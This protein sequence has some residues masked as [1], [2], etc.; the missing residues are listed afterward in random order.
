MEQAAKTPRPRQITIAIWL[1]IAEGVLFLIAA[2]FRQDWSDPWSFVTT[3]LFA[4]FTL[5][6]IYLILR[7]KGWVRWVLA[8]LTLFVCVSTG[9]MTKPGYNWE[10]ANKLFLAAFVLKRVLAFTEL[11]LLFSSPA[12]AWFGKSRKNVQEVIEDKRM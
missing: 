2:A 6:W 10:E 1:L 11:L 7:R 9:G 8:V 12:N 4:S 3:P 5:L